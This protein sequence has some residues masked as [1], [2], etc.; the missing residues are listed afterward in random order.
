VTL[1]HGGYSGAT[2][3]QASSGGFTHGAPGVTIT[4]VFVTEGN[5]PG[6]AAPSSACG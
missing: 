6:T 5:A 2:N 3:F 4:D 1:D